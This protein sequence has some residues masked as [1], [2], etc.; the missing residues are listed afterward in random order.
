M[1]YDRHAA[2]R[3]RDSSILSTLCEE[4][5]VCAEVGDDAIAAARGCGGPVDRNEGDEGVDRNEGD[6]GC[7]Q[8]QSDKLVTERHLRKRST[9]EQTHR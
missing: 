3:L 8:K 9:V 5:V 2:S 4:V 6:E 1:R 7:I